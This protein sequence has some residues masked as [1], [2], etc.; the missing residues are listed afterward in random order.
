MIKIEEELKY[1]SN[2]TTNI[3]KGCYMPYVYGVIINPHNGQQNK[4]AQLFLVDTGAAITILN[5]SFDFLFKG[6]QTPIIDN[7]PIQYGRS[8]LSDG[9]PVSVVLPIYNLKLKIKGFEF[10]IHAAYDKNIATH[11]LLGHLG[12]LNNFAHLG[13]S[14]KRHKLTLIKE[15]GNNYA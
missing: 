4:V 2:I 13:I 12:F 1:V 8:L 7:M 10:D 5:R 11:S 3:K 6:N 15:E 14:Q 9:K